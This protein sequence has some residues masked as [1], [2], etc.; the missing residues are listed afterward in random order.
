M[1]S[2]QTY[3][4]LDLIIANKIKVQAK[5]AIRFNPIDNYDQLYSAYRLKKNP[6]LKGIT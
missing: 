1:R 4:L 6:Q 2:S 3:L 5:R